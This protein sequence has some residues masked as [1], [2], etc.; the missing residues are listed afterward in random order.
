[1]SEDENHGQDLDRGNSHDQTKVSSAEEAEDTLS[2]IPPH[3]FLWA[4]GG[5]LSL[6]PSR[7]FLNPVMLKDGSD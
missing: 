7:P 3:A 4:P 6:A 5:C 1:M 2:N